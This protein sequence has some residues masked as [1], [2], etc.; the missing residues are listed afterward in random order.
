MGAR[1]ETIL[2]GDP[3]AFD[4]IRQG[5]EQGGDLLQLA[6]RRPDAQPC[7]DRQAERFGTDGQRI[8]SD[9]AAPPQS[10]N[11]PRPARRRWS[12]EP[13]QISDADPG[14]ADQG[15]KN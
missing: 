8:A 6:G 7:S 12:D 14:V 4:N 1:D 15:V 2:A 9:P 13:S 10:P 3:V 5:A 11:P